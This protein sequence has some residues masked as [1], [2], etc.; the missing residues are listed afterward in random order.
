MKTIFLLLLTAGCVYGQFK[1][2]SIGVVYLTKESKESYF[3]TIALN[4]STLI[5]SDKKDAFKQS[6]DSIAHTGNILFFDSKGQLAVMYKKLNFKITPWCASDSTITHRV[7]L[8]M[9]IKKTDFKRKVEAIADIQ[10]ISCFV[11]LNNTHV[12]TEHPDYTVSPDIRLRG[13]FDTD[14]QMDCFIWTRN[15]VGICE[16]EPTNQLGI[17]LQIAKKTINLRCCE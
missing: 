4:A 3:F 12:K 8:D 17:K 10:N 7:T 9:V 13:D 15:E 1:P 2:N 5:K 16:G 6:I 14:G 11:L